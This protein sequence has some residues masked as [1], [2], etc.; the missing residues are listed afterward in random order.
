[1]FKMIEKLRKSGLL[2]EKMLIGSDWSDSG[3]TK[4][5]KNPAT[6]EVIGNVPM[7][8]ES[9]VKKAIETAYQSQKQWAKESAYTRSKALRKLYEL[10]IEYK[11]ELA[12]IMTIESGKVITESRGEVNY[13]A[14]FVEWYS[15]EAK[16]TYGQCVPA[17]PVNKRIRVI[18][19]PV[20][21]AAIITP[22]NFPS[23]MITR[24]IAP[25]IAVGCSCIV[26]P[27]GY[28]PFSALALGELSLRAGIPAGVLNIV[29]GSSNVIGNALLESDKVRK[30]SFTGST[31]VGKQ[32]M[33]RSADTVKRI[34][35]ELGGHAP[36]IVFD[37]ADIDKAIE[38][39]IAS[40]F[41]N[42]GQ[43]CICANRFYVQKGVY[44]EFSQKLTK[45][46]ES[47]KVANG[48]D[49]SSQ[50]GPLINQ[51]G[52]EKVKKHLEDAVNKGAKILTGGKTHKEGENFFEPT[53]IGDVHHNMIIT[54]EETFG[55][56]APLIP[57]DTEEEAVT[58]ANN[59]RYG[60]AS[61]YYT[62]DA[63]RLIR[64]SEALEYGIV[65][66]NDGVPSTPQAPFGGIKES[67]IGREGGFYGLDEYLEYKFI[68][69]GIKN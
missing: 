45:A 25:A 31:E 61:Y 32:L 36:F 37:D 60:L 47:L 8:D 13:S 57:F 23:A 34:S 41:R 52:V 19:Q 51:A 3:K 24:K 50:I 15:E 27:S 59:T 17:S 4:T 2:K 1:M 10:M 16:R 12:Y 48:L 44:D 55:P 63:D 65:G 28:T 56:V 18:R 6:G 40:K 69:Q 49:D 22:W 20:G 66:A 30:L 5:I 26:K 38:G 39:A 33:K 35:L 14:G 62:S 43:T 67:G 7:A 68:S 42:S 11:E 54:K 9:N 46:V 53:V 29:T 21:V 58:Q 64:V